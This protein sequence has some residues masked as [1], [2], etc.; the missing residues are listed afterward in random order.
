[1]KTLLT[2]LLLAIST[3]T[4]T[5]Q[6][7]QRIAR[8]PKVSYDWQPGFI[9]ITEL[10]GAFG[11]G[12]TTEGLTGGYYGITSVAGYQF[13]RNILTGVGAGVHF[14]EGVT[15][16]PLYLDIRYRMSAQELV[17]YIA[18]SGGIMLDFADLGNT[19]VF[20][21]PLAGLKYVVANRVGVSLSA[22]LMVIA[23]GSNERMSFANI[24]LGLEIKVRE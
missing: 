3:S 15:F 16:F 6:L 13:T 12:L 2:L 21:N 23:G 7:D 1:M 19:R 4:M 8:T 9:S 17:P 20:I 24:K 14:H 5:A 11:L 10:T 18:G 22:G